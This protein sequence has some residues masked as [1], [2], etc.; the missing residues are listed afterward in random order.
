LKVHGALVEQPIVTSGWLVQKTGLTAATVNKSLSLLIE[1]GVVRELTAQ[2][3]NRV[4][5]YFEFIEI[6]NRG[7]ELP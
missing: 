3:R 2:K 6:L 7:S 1:I 4:F 5:S